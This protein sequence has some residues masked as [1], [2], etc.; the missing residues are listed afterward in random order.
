MWNAD[1]KGSQAYARALEQC[2]ILTS[3][4]ASTLVDGLKVSALWWWGGKVGRS[5][6]SEFLTRSL[7]RVT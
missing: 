3:D 7:A 2:G 6:N 1:I 4:E 5:S